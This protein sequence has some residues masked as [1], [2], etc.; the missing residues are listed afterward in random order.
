VEAGGSWSPG[1]AIGDVWT[2]TSGSGA[3]LGV[4]KQTAVGS[5]TVT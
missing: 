1:G 2:V 5:V 3:C 4:F